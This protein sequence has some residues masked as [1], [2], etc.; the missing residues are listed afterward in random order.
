MAP[1]KILKY[2]E[3]TMV[4]AIMAVREGEGITKATRLYGVPHSTLINKIKGKVPEEKKMGPSSIL[5]EAE[6]N[7]PNTTHL[8]QP[9][10]VSVFRSLKADA[11]DYERCMTHES[12]HS[13]GARGIIACKP[14]IFSVEHLLYIESAM[15]S[16]RAEEFREAEGEGTW[17]S[18]ESAR[19]LFNLGLKLRKRAMQQAN[20]SDM[21]NSDANKIQKEKNGNGISDS[22]DLNDTSAPSTSK[23]PPSMPSTSKT[24]PSTPSRPT[25]TPISTATKSKEGISPAFANTLF[26]Q[27]NHHKNPKPQERNYDYLML[28]PLRNG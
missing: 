8:L 7:L 3:G 2:P 23:M 12:R 9:A 16:G 1:Q 28:L 21:N 15:K 24:L 18:E 5:T 17:N 13:D 14:T 25:T 20:H 27:Q 4:K 6:E 19:E 26:G 11:V 22:C 10:D